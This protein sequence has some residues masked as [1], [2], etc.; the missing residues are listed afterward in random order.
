MGRASDILNK[1][2]ETGRASKMLGVQPI[3]PAK[4]PAATAV[5]TPKAVSPAVQ[6]IANN[7][8]T[9]LSL[10]G[11][12]TRNAANNV[13]LP[14]TPATP[15]PSIMV[16][17]PAPKAQIHSTAPKEA[18]KQTQREIEN[19]R[20]QK[21]A[22]K[23]ERAQ[24]E[25][26]N[27]QYRAGMSR[28]GVNSGFFDNKIAEN[29]AQIAQI[30]NKIA[31]LDND[32]SNLK[33]KEKEEYNNYLQKLRNSE[34]FRYNTAPR[35]PEKGS[36]IYNKVNAGAR[37]ISPELVKLQ[38]AIV[39]HYGNITSDERDMYNYLYHTRGEEA[40]NEYLD[41]IE[42]DLRAREGLKMHQEYNEKKGIPR[43][44]RG[45]QIAVAAGAADFGKGI[46]Q[47]FSEEA[48]NTA[49][50]QYAAGKIS[51]NASGVSKVAFDLARTAANMAPSILLSIATGN[52]AIGT[53]ALGTS[54]AGNAY[55]EKVREGY[56][57]D[58]AK[59]YAALV[60]SSEA[61]LQ[62]ALGGIG[63]LGG[64]ISGKVLAKNIEAIDKAFLR[65]SAKFAKAGLS[66]GM[67]E[68]LQSYLEPAFA[69]WV[70]NEKYEAPEL[71]DVVY[72]F[73][74]SALM[75]GMF[76]TGEIINSE[77]ERRENQ[78]QKNTY[79]AD[80][81]AGKYDYDA[82]VSKP[83]I[84]VVTID[85]SVQYNADGH[86]RKNIIQTALKNAAKVGTQEEDGGVSIYVEDVGHN[87]KLYGT[88]LKHG[89]DRRLQQN[90]A[91]TLKTG[92]LLKNAIRI[93]EL[94]PKKE[95]TS[96]SYVLLSVA[97]NENN[98]PYVVEFVVN[99]FD[100]T[101]ES[102]DVLY[103]LNAK[104]EPAVRNAPKSTGT[105][106]LVTGSSISI[107]ELLDLSR[108]HFSDVL[109][110]SVLRHYGYASRPEGKLGE[111]ALYSRKVNSTIKGETGVQSTP[112]VNTGNATVDRVVT[113]LMGGKQIANSQ[114]SSVLNDAEAVR[115]LR[116][117]AGLR[118]MGKT[119]AEQRAAV[120]DVLLKLADEA[121]EKRSATMERLSSIADIDLD[122]I[123]QTSNAQR[124]MN[125]AVRE[126]IPTMLDNA[127]TQRN[128]PVNVMRTAPDADLN[129]A[130]KNEYGYGDNGARAYVEAVKNLPDVDRVEARQEFTAAYMKGLQGA[131]VNQKNMSDMQVAAYEAGVNDSNADIRRGESN[132]KNVAS[133]GENAGF[134]AENAPD[135]ANTAEREVI[136]KLYK[137]F[138]VVGGYTNLGNANAKLYANRGVAMID[139]D[140]NTEND[141]G[142]AVSEF[143]HAAHEVAIHRLMELA[144]KEGRA[145]INAM[146]RQLDPK[147]ENRLAEAKRDF[148]KSQG[149]DIT[150]S[151]AME[152]VVANEILAL[153]N[154]D[155]KKFEAALDRIMAGEDVAAKT[156]LQKFKD[157]LAEVI[158]YLNR[159]LETVGL[160]EKRDIQASIK[161]LENLRNLFETAA[162]KAVEANREIAETTGAVSDKNGNIVAE[163]NEDGTS[164]LSLKTYEESGKAELH[165]WLDRN[166]KNKKLTRAEA[167]E[168]ASQLDYYYE[169]CTKY[170]SKYVPFGKWSEAEIVRGLDG[171]PLMSVVKQN[172]E[173]KL[174]IDF[175]L[176]CKK[177][178]TLDGLY[179]AMIEDGFMDNIAE[180][181]EAEIA[182]INKIIR[183]SGLET[184]CTLCFVDAKRYRQAKVADSFVSKYNELVNMLAPKDANIEH[185]DFS[186]GTTSAIGLHTMSNSEVSAG[187]N[188]LNK[189]IKE[190][191]EGSVVGR[192]A[193]HLKAN[194]QDRKLLKRS[195]FMDS[196]GFVK[197]QK[198]NPDVFKLYNSSKGSGGPKASFPDVQYLGEIL[199]QRKFNPTKAYEVGGVRIQSFS[200]YVAR[201]VFDY[202]QMVADLSAKKLPAHA[203][204]KEELFVL[205]FGKTGIKIN[206]SLVPAV[207]EDGIAPGLDKDGNY[208]WADGHSFASKSTEKGSANKGYELAVKIQNAEGY[209]Q[210]CGTIAVGVSDAHIEKLLADKN[211]RMVIPYHSSGL[212]H[213][214]KEMGG[215]N[216]YDDYTT[217][218]NTRN[219]SDGKKIEGDDF[220]FNEALRKLGDAKAAADAYLAWCDKNNYIPKFDDFAHHKD[221]KVRENYYKLLIDFATY[222]G[223]G[224]ATPQSAVR[225]NFPVEGDEFGSMTSLIGEGLD[226]DAVLEAERTG[227]IPGILK[228]VKQELGS[229]G[230]DKYSLKNDNEPTVKMKGLADEIDKARL[231]ERMAKFSFKD[232]NGKALSAAQIEYFKNSKVR[233]ANGNL[234]VMYHGTSAGGFTVFDTY[235]YYSKF[236]LFGNGAYFTDSKDIA[237]QY[238]RK[239]RG[240]NPQV[241][242]V[243]LNITNP[244]DMDAEAN[245]DAWN[246]ALQKTGED[247][248][249]L[250][251]KITN[252]TAFKRMVEDLEY[253]EVYSYDAA[254]IVRNVFENMGYDGITH[255]GG[256]RV[257]RSDGTKHRVYIAFEKEQ[258]KD[259]TNTK[260]T[261]NADIHFSLKNPDNTAEKIKGLKEAVEKYGEMKP[262]E[263]PHRQVSVP[264]KTDENK[265]VRRATRTI[266]ESEAATDELVSEMEQ[267]IVNGT[268]SYVPIG[269]KATIEKTEAHI[270]YVGFE[271]AL[272]EWREVVDGKAP[273]TKEKMA[274]GEML[275]TSAAH[276][277]DTKTA[278]QIAAELAAEGTRAGQTVQAIRM[279]KKM[280]PEGK[281]YYAEKSLEKWQQELNDRYGDKAPKLKINDELIENLINARTDEEAA[282]A[283]KALYK[284]IGEQIPPTA[285]DKWNAWRYLAMLGNTRTH[286]RN[287]FGNI[288]FIPMRATK[289]AV[290]ALGE[291]ILIRDKGK[292]SASV[293]VYAPT[294]EN[295]E[296]WDFVKKDSKN[297]GSTLFGTYKYSPENI[298]ADN[299][300][301]F[302]TKW[303][304]F[305]RKTNSKLLEK[306]DGIF[307]SI[308]YRDSLAQY[309]KAN[310][311]SLDFLKSGTAE[312]K[313]ALEQGRQ[314]AISEALKATYT[315]ASA[316]AD[317][318]SEFTRV[319]ANDSKSVKAA[320]IAVEGMLPFKKTPINI[321][322]RGVEYSPI[323]IVTTLLTCQSKL[324]KGEI[325]ASQV[326]D[327]LASGLTGSGVLVLGAFLAAQ[328]LLKAGLG[329][330]KEDYFEELQGN[331]G[332]SLVFGDKSYTIDWAAPLS[333]PLL[334]GAELWNE[335]SQKDEKGITFA[336][337]LDS[338]GKISEPMV[339]MSM[340]QGLQD[341]IETV[342]FSDNK[343][344]G[345]FAG[346]ATNYATQAIPTALGQ[347]ARTIDGTRRSTYASKDGVVPASVGRTRNKT[348][349]K[350]PGLSKTLEPYVDSWGREEKT[351]V[352]QRV[353]ENFV[354]PGYY[355][356]NKATVVD[357]EVARL[358]KQTG[359]KSVLPTVAQN[360]VEYAEQT[361]YKTPEEKT[362][363]QKT[364]GGTSYSLREAAYKSD[365]YKRMTDEQ[366][367]EVNEKIAS[368]ANARAKAEFFKGRSIKYKADSFVGKLDAAKKAG[369]AEHVA[370]IAWT[371]QKD[372]E[373]IKDKDGDS[374]NYSASLRK[375]KAI[376]NA[377]PTLS[378]EKRKVLYELFGV[379]KDVVKMSD[380][381]VERRLNSMEKKYG[382][383]NK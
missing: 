320:K 181:S 33:A 89:L 17:T 23:E 93:N 213:I 349:A 350:I 353:L 272:K 11:Q 242:A 367:V 369:I 90:A 323:Q 129:T 131:E 204:T 341:A 54:A 100:N 145:F 173:Y 176:V 291:K 305:L 223:Q 1:A 215:I 346:A 86:T 38:E 376:D 251:G 102:M 71:E 30:D 311:Y 373:S 140:F 236:G 201:L 154:Y 14:L 281:L 319:R 260:P 123:P 118:T 283:E 104:K 275:L 101:V 57:A 2:N 144:P 214:V 26:K 343:L 298:I 48:V 218:Q 7:A 148:Y 162:A 303:I 142:R 270:E 228:Q 185:F 53:A 179:R 211:I 46:S 24:W 52:S 276:A 178:R 194:P 356:E 318:L 269:D 282:E 55:A 106:L 36:E 75:G 133:Y 189:V 230:K 368:V 326:I 240:K 265:N 257:N 10:P 61:L 45:G 334:V 316:L 271:S 308:T 301:I 357:K 159:I 113:E 5:Q 110:E 253:A 153:Y 313:S 58:E 68:T 284:H 296:I 331:Q 4:Q 191:G 378:L 76:E 3:T 88:G 359:E 79:L 103:S 370:I 382:K 186:G 109:P 239:G 94:T 84:N 217:K 344:A 126:D 309:I 254:E 237:E 290:K 62:Y 81:G 261:S 21:N 347:V 137:A 150:L 379:S 307:K 190:H 155:A 16:S 322:K 74:T 96:G 206:M 292:R 32:I 354:S 226:K 67:E 56:D 289:N 330:D 160:K 12:K 327:Q 35:S 219:K 337:L 147:G 127:K 78:A 65:V 360:R 287:I 200:D 212:N 134:T 187:L 41:Y 198:A 273:M 335:M 336:S 77:I 172:G 31:L 15:A 167:D 358:Y 234:L 210:N 325:T 97:K 44:I 19:L 188:K 51:E 182:T 321:L 250:E 136:N 263:K 42:E 195:D 141:K 361:Y 180:L 338:L 243:Y 95:N 244:I 111:S 72:T 314:Y 20:T 139:T 312:A 267:E 98:E 114:I 216:K 50:V 105:P 69:S 107:S 365:S 121:T 224:N 306:E 345:V 279:L 122:N 317:K 43:M 28:A 59:T 135:K 299:R 192:I 288:L 66:E 241:Y 83:D 229:G 13:P 203:Y 268:F 248:S 207:V 146:Y 249:L 352:V 63:K 18:Y 169:L 220:N 245:V 277:G 39:G 258:I 227:K 47:M 297:L 202:I 99:E 199:K 339:E 49:P 246:R 274:L 91:V 70:F 252:E 193:K 383:Y 40:A 381:S 280:S 340:L 310:G 73:I 85:D 295:R 329:D 60:G 372:V 164:V 168:I 156:G 286:A 9:P 332:Y 333:L 364:F 184:A 222:D 293:S 221:A 80:G 262:G 375:R 232:S 259:V 132:I 342:S 374:V 231:G 163:F 205:Q 328:G 256:G 108:S 380:E 304:E 196:E 87:V 128:A 197:V 362:K 351:G 64:K 300:Q 117:T 120:K 8:K 348:A 302:K 37:A 25:K 208:V 119:K 235:A 157:I 171:K 278:M 170:K 130:V 174:N 29:N 34:N 22:A 225:M 158:D 151:E 27:A 363:Y 143:Y 238:T 124:I 183:K 6:T 166:V 285:L 161:E 264:K 266:M 82:L 377:R 138:G 255:I 116:V 175:S 152:E 371:L 92:E 247:F 177:R 294:K 366:K 355:S 165:K 125:T 112:T 315:D 209:S 149:E 115:T 233:D 324:K